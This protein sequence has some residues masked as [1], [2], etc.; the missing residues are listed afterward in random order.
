MKKFFHWSVVL[1]LFFAGA[2]LLVESG[3]DTLAALG[4]GVCGMATGFFI[5][6]FKIYQI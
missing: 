6:K 3:A 2:V 4:A 1:L 5:E